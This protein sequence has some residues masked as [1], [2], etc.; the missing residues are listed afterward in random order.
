MLDLTTH[1][2]P[3][4]G[5]PGEASTHA[6]EAAAGEPARVILGAGALVLVA[7]LLVPQLLPG[8]TH[9]YLR[10]MAAVMAAGALI[11]LAE[12]ARY[13]VTSLNLFVWALILRLLALT[14]CYAL[15][16]H[17]GGP[18]LGPDSTT[19]YYEGVSLANAGFHLDV[20]PVRMYGSYDVAHYY[21]FAGVVR[22][23]GADLFALQA[24]NAGLT[25]L[26]VPLMYYIARLVFPS[27]ALA[28]GVVL[29]VHPTLVLMSAV[30]L[31]KDPS[32][33]FGTA[34][35]VWG[36][37]RMT[38]SE[39]LSA[40]VVFAVL[41]LA[42]GVYLRMARF[43]TFAYLEMALVGAVLY[44]RAA[45]T[46][47]FRRTAAAGIA[48][49]VILTAEVVPARAGWPP[50]PV[51][52]MSSVGYVLGTPAMSQYGL[53]LFDRLQGRRFDERG[54]PIEHYGPTSGP[55]ALVGSAITFSANLFRRLYGPFV[56]IL[57]TDWRFQALQAGD[58]LLYPGMVV[59][60]ALLPI[61]IV[62]LCV[63]GSRI[64]NRT[65]MR[66]AMVL[67]WIF[68]A[69]YFAQYLAIN[70]SYRQRDVML[71]VLLVFAW[72]GFVWLRRDERWRVWFA[73]YWIALALVAVLHLLVRGLLLR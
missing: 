35:L 10:V 28:L 56:W 41:V 63:T 66:F 38:T 50:S 67:L 25:A 13:R 58:Y 71:P 48:A 33:I 12:P 43:Y 30:D 32:I 34:L 39:R 17:G 5:A 42:A 54:Q 2:P 7:L 4:T 16:L 24:M 26:A 22:Y 46:P 61:T 45:R 15:S 44:M 57:P 72:T 6:S 20:D 59:W 11:A 19:Y 52:V 31:L 55:L 3:V 36:I 51:M 14:A 60:Y 53:G 27:A 73:R 65:E 23:F 47:V 1:P 8:V 62:G 68:T 70:L 49:A 9:A 29:V 64:V 40:L 21:L 69:V 18:F 37:F